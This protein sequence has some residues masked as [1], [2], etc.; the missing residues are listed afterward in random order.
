MAVGRQSASPAP[1]TTAGVTIERIRLR[2]YSPLRPAARITS[3]HLRV[4]SSMNL[5]N[6]AAVPPF[7]SSP[8][9]SSFCFTSGSASA[10]M[11]SACSRSTIGCGVRCRRHEAVPAGRDHVGKALLPQGGSVRINRAA[12]GRRH[13]QHAQATALDVRQG[14]ADRGQRGVETARQQFGV[15]HVVAAEGNDQAFDAGVAKQQFGGQMRLRARARRT[16]GQAFGL[17]LAVGDHFLKGLEG[18]LRV[19]DQEQRRHARPSPPAAG[20]CGR[21]SASRTAASAVANGAAA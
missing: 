16:K 1:S 10:R 9:A 4:S 8:W 21:S 15:G 7:A 11:T 2:A 12:R 13:A 3:P 6:S 18:R 17:R 19:D 20:P 14:R 5:P